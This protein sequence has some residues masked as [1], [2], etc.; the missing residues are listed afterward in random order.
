MLTITVNRNAKAAVDY[1]TKS[2]VRDDYFFS[3]K[4]VL[5]R[6]YGELTKDLELPDV[7]SKKAFSALIRNRHPITGKALAAREVK[8][9]R[10]N[11]EFTF[12][13]V[14]SASIAMALLGDR[15]ILNAHRRAV[16]KAMSA[17]E[18]MAMT[19]KRIE[20][21]KAYVQTGK[22][23]YGRYD[24]FTSRPVKDEVLG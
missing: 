22:L 12:S 8:G 6:W 1:H 19:Q 13:A 10:T 11:Y 7:I 23:I 16:K 9:R 5:G 18:E 14:K 15:E 17:V 3:G 2:L 20:G 4:A 21:K 24:H